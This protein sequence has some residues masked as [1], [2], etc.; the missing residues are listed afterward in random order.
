MNKA[1]TVLLLL[2]LFIFSIAR[3]DD[4]RGWRGLEKQ[5]CADSGK[6]ATEWSPESHVLW[7]VNIEGEGHSSPVVNDKYV[8]ITSA[9]LNNNNFTL[10]K[11]IFRILALF[12]LFII[13]YSFNICYKRIT[14]GN[15]IKKSEYFSEL[16]LSAILGLML[17]SFAVM[18]WMYFGEWTLHKTFLN[19][20]FSGSV[21]L[22]SILLLISL[23]QRTSMMRI[24]SAILIIS[25][26]VLL[27]KNTPRPDYFITEIFYDPLNYWLVPASAGSIVLPVLVS[28]YLIF[29][30]IIRKIKNERPVNHN[31]PEFKPVFAGRVLIITFITGSSGFFVIPLISAAKYFLVNTMAMRIK[32]ILS[33]RLFLEPEFAYPFFMIVLWLL[34]FFWFIK[35]RLQRKQ[36]PANFLIYTLLLTC[37]LLFFFML[38]IVS[39]EAQYERVVYCID[40]LTGEIKW[41]QKCLEGPAIEISNYNSQATPTPLIDDRNVYAYF[42]SAGLVSFGMDGRIN[43]ENRDLPFKSPHGIGSSPVFCNNNIVL[44]NSMADNSYVSEIDPYSGKENWKN[45]IS[46]VSIQSGEYRTPAVYNTG[47]INYII[48]WSTLRRVLVLYD[49]S[50]GKAAFRYTTDWGMAGEA[51]SSAVL[52]NGVIYLTN[53]ENIV[54]V[55]LK[56]IFNNKSPV[57]WKTNLES[58]GPETSS[59]VCY[60]GMIFMV[61]DNGFASCLECATGKILWQEK[62]RGSFLSSPVA[63]GNCIY[64]SNN[65]GETTVVESS[66]KFKLISRN[67]LKEGIYAT[68]ALADGQL[69]IRTKN[70]L[71]C[72][73]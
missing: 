47:G 18:Y 2:M 70:S 7:K 67:D 39:H 1:G 53:V 5:A 38:N 40:R 24:V 20:L 49:A 61:S 44:L 59:P 42:G 50:T 16:S 33:M 71:W 8:V 66:G 26:S 51:V 17:F 10:N 36:N 22:F 58:R 28:V 15:G 73:N 27:F 32:P 54:A 52:S 65:F 4:W 14:N 6:Y 45:I 11:I 60:A 3:A 72:I 13:L 29:I 46:N 25:L 55:D 62:I 48:E 30:T 43:W 34:F 69:F 23:T 57:I 19:Y 37:S 31:E 68:P 21:S 12:S 64:F 41:K 63:A 35:D 9:E 56:K